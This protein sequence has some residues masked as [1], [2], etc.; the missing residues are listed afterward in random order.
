MQALYR[1]RFDDL[2]STAASM[3]AAYRDA[4]ATT[5]RERGH[6]HPLFWAPFMASGDWR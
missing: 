4:L 5:R 2:R 3:R 1:A 6:A